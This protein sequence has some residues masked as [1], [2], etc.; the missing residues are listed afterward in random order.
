ML[1]LL[2]VF[3]WFSF[4]GLFHTY[5]LYPL[6]MRLWAKGKLP[7]QII[8]KA[9][10]ENWP[11]VIVLMA[12][13]NEEKVIRQKM[14]SLLAQHYPAQKV[15]IFIGSDCSTDQTNPILEAY[16]QQYPQQVHFIPFNSR[17]GKPGII[18]QLFLQATKNHPAIEHT[19]LVVTDA[20]VLLSEGVV[21]SL[22][23]HFKNPAIDIVDAHMVHYGMQEAGISK[24]EN[25]YISSEVRL[26]H[27]ESLVWGKMIGPF[28]GCYAV[29]A[30]RFTPVP[31][32]FLVDDF[33]ITMKVFEQGGLAIN[34][35][36]AIC[37][38]AVSH[39]IREEYRRKARISAGNFQN[40]LSFRHLWWPPIQ[41]LAFAFFSHKVLRWLG[42]FFF[43]ILLLSSF[44]L[45]LNHLLIYEVAFLAVAFV[46]FAVPLLDYLLRLINIHVLPL[47]GIRYL[48]LMN[49]ALLNG[50]INFIK[51]IKN[52]V[53]EPPKRT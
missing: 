27:W 48:L 11:D 47:R 32:K 35:L 44:A 41:P 31:A 23:Q 53:W 30:S 52:N 12:V 39:E 4:L 19:V 1:F 10:D 18:N 25:Q 8:F 21:R 51:G 17:T 22:A 37:Y 45:A 36:D 16:A 7:N 42:P 13:F 3:F 2:Q 6:L 34:E 49:L 15:S 29:R 50:F 28:G 9:T 43:I 40:L 38:E 26:K 14:D 46:L 20:N 5:F 24:A 33:F